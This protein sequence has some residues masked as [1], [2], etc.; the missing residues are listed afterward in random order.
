MNTCNAADAAF[1]RSREVGTPPGSGRAHWSWAL[2]W[3]APPEVVWWVYWPQRRTTGVLMR[4]ANVVLTCEDDTIDLQYV[5][6]LEV[7]CDRVSL[8]AAIAR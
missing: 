5:H 6:E 7:T 2:P 3:N 1:G 8:D 4:L